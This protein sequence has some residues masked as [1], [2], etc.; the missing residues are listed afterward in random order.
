YAR[1]ISLANHFNKKVVLD[2]SGEALRSVLKS[3]AKPTVIK[4]NLGR[5]NTIN[6]ENQLAIV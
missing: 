3:S 1:L 6:W 4:P 5:I 2:C